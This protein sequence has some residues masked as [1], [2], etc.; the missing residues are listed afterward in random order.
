MRC[1]FDVH[2]VSRIGWCW[3]CQRHKTIHV[4]VASTLERDDKPNID[5][6]HGH[7]SQRRTNGHRSRSRSRYP[8]RSSA[9]TS[10][11]IDSIPK[12]CHSNR[13][14]TASHRRIVRQWRCVYLWQQSVRSIGHWRFAAVLWAGSSEIKFS[15][16]SSGGRQQSHG[17]AVITWRRLHIRQSFEGPIGSFAARHATQC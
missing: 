4:S 2:F 8:S 13:L 14:R 7:R 15:D 9:T 3:R 6:S 10:T 16:C 5:S 12:S 1:V 11:S 17:A